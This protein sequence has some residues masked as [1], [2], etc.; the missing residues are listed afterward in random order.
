MWYPVVIKEKRVNDMEELLAK[1]E[2]LEQE[3]SDLKEEIS[4]LRQQL[5]MYKK[6]LYGQ[7]SERTEVVMKNT[8]QLNFFD[9]AENEANKKVRETEQ[10]AVEAHTRKPKRTHDEMLRDLPVE[11]VVHEVEDKTCNKCGSE[12]KTVGR[13]F[14]RDELIYVPSKLFVRKHYAEVVK[15]TVCGK[16]EQEDSKSTDVVP[17]S[18]RKATA[19]SPL[20]PHSFCSPELL[21]HI[22]YEKYIQAVPMYRQEKDFAAMGVRLSRNT[23]ANWIIY[24]AKEWCLPVWKQMKAELLN[25]SVLH[26]DETV[27]QVHREPGKKDKT[28]SRMWVYCAPKSAG[29][30]NILFQYTPTR[31]GAHAVKFLEDYS[32]YLVCDGYD[33][34]SKLKNVKRC[35]CFAHVRRKFTEA[36]PTDKDLLKT[37]KAA[38]GLE[39]CNKLFSLEQE[40]EQMEPEGKQKQRQ[41]RSKP[42]LD[43]F[44]AWLNTI[45]PTGG[46]KLAKAVQ[47]ALNERKYLYHF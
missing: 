6:A 11:E 8:E 23:M 9:E 42:V 13:E 27:V 39:W 41:E 3:N 37:S 34:Y 20:I 10:I 40:Y 26:A 21:A 1:Q 18:F 29:H 4:D 28:D 47:Y 36:L 38:E 33:G 19:P 7:K 17:F 32:G 35:G 30:S 5:A 43:G 24:A 44:F 2:K 15:C 45:H 25:E 14:V 12:M 16:D 31:A 46:S 22:I